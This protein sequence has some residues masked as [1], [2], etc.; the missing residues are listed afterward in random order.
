[1]AGEVKVIQSKRTEIESLLL[2]FSE[3]ITKGM[4]ET[5]QKLANMVVATNAG[6]S[7]CEVPL[8]ELRK[9]GK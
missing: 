9:V 1:M 2:D 3:L 6:Y 8:L 5:G 7:E 4:Q